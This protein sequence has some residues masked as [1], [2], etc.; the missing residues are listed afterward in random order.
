MPTSQQRQA[1]A[2]QKRPVSTVRIEEVPTNG[3]DKPA[4][5]KGGANDD[6]DIE[7]FSFEEDEAAA[8]QKE[9]VAKQQE[10]THSAKDM[11]ELRTKLQAAAVEQG[12]KRRKGNGGET[13]ASEAAAR[14][15][16]LLREAAPTATK[17]DVPQL[18]RDG[19][20]PRAPP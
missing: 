2:D 20:E 14:A 7:A 3:K 12:V 1:A 17:G 18:P 9:F 16:Q 5:A 8:L 10:A 19:G 11:L 4:D 6:M 13:V 15:A